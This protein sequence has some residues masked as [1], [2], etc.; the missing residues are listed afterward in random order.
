MVMVILVVLGVLVT[1]T[2]SY[3]LLTTP[4]H[5]L[6][7]S[8]FHA[9]NSN[10][11]KN[12]NIG[13]NT[14]TR[15]LFQVAEWFGQLANG[16]SPA[17]SASSLQAGKA[18]SAKLSAL[19]DVAE[20][21]RKE[22]E[23]IFW[24]TGN[25]DTSLWAD[26]C[27][28]SDPF[29]SFG[30]A[31]GSTKRFKSNADNLG[32]LVVNPVLKVTSF[33]V[34]SGVEFVSDGKRNGSLQKRDAVGGGSGSGATAAA[35]ADSSSSDTDTDAAVSYDVVKVG[36]TFSSKLKL[37]WNPVLA[38]AGETTHY[39]NEQGLI[40]RYEERWKSRAWDVVRRL[41]VPTPRA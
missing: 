26:D 24:A 13:G 10:G 30:G 32:K 19:D 36:W 40:V 11:D 14:A 34:E 15:G 3:A 1:S 7:S 31:P 9:A 20:T 39:L 29:S 35:T 37:P 41:F 2:R 23:A 17:A 38:A 25:M 8:R 5:R 18:S 27:V 33:S 21:I 6:S 16:I 22:Y 12:N 4:K 28:F